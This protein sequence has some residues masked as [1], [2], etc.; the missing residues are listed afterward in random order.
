MEASDRIK[1]P[2][3]TAGRQVVATRRLRKIAQANTMPEVD[4]RCELAEEAAMAQR[5]GEQRWTVERARGVARVDAKELDRKVDGAFHAIDDACMTH[6]RAAARGIQTSQADAAELIRV[7]CLGVGV[8]AITR[9]TYEAEFAAMKHLAA[10]YA[11]ADVK[12]AAAT[13]GATAYFDAI[14]DSCDA[15]EL[16]IQQ[17]GPAI[18]GRQLAALRR[19]SHE[20]LC[21]L[22]ALVLGQTAGDSKAALR[23]ELLTPIDEQTKALRDQ[24]AANAAPT[25]LNPGTG[26]EEPVIVIPSDELEP[27]EEP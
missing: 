21:E 1:Q 23:A 11:T 2:R 4:A 3:L 12:A 26:E 13:I 22:I 20:E 8:G 16:A 18:T 17:A 19:Q 27:V 24:R 25:D 9:G 7:S 14:V 10:Q 6:I 5:A 15:Y